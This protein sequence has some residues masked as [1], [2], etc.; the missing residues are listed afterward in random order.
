MELEM[1]IQRSSIDEKTVYGSDQKRE[2]F[3]IVKR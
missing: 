3:K 2:T 1:N